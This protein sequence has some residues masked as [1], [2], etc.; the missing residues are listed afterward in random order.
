MPDDHPLAALAGTW[1]G[2]GEG[3]YPTIA[4]FTYTEELVIAP[5]PGRPLAHWR[6]TTRDGATGEPRHAE[7]GFLR[8]VAQGLELVVAHGF[9]VVEASVG[10]FDGDVLA[11]RTSGLL[12]APSAKQV[13]EVERR[14]ELDGETLRYTIAMAAVGVPLTH[15]LRAELRRA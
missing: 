12:G 9:G 15:H 6:S 11:L 10:T 8:S 14:Y 7:S 5:V 4:D 3:V 13:D 1:R 2:A